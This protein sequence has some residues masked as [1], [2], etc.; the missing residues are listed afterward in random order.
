MIISNI[1]IDFLKFK[2]ITFFL[3]TIQ[4]NIIN[5]QLQL[6]NTTFIIRAYELFENMMSKSFRKIRIII[7]N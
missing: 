5:T 7:S 6:F 1:N 2:R 4:Q 3:N